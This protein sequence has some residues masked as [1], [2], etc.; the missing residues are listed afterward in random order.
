M[1]VLS[2]AGVGGA[3]SAWAGLRRVTRRRRFG[4][5]AAVD[6]RLAGV[7]PPRESFTTLNV[8][9]CEQPRAA[10]RMTH[11]KA[12]MPPGSG[13]TQ[14]RFRWGGFRLRRSQPEASHELQRGGPKVL[15]TPGVGRPSDRG[16]GVLRSGAA[17]SRSRGWALR[18]TVLPVAC[19]RVGINA[20]GWSGGRTARPPRAPATAARDHHGGP[21]VAVGSARKH[22]AVSV[23]E[24]L[25][26]APLVVG[27]GEIGCG[28]VLGRSG[29]RLW[30]FIVDNFG[31]REGRHARHRR[32]EDRHRGDA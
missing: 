11:P 3:G 20:G 29:R 21:P 18:A 2:V 17:E 19:R 14:V 25:D 16:V 13:E 15:R 4:G 31:A 6:A 30:R 12:W 23:V 7:R 1:V 5:R 10:G 9:A 24:V 8:P 32:T 27:F 22:A 26:A 28:R